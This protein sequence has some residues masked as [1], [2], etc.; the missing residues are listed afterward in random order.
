MGICIFW[1]WLPAPISI[2]GPCP[3]LVFDGPGPLFVFTGPGHNL[4]LPV[5]RFTVN[6]FYSSCLL[7]LTRRP[8][9][10]SYFLGIMW[11][12]SKLQL[13][14]ISSPD[15]SPSHTWLIILIRFI[16]LKNNWINPWMKTEGKCN[17]SV[18]NEFK[19]IRES[20]S[21]HQIMRVSK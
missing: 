17:E 21:L 6:V 1:P 19:I 20:D 9:L 8:L 10:C 13:F 4:C 2:E 18:N 3:Q 14:E 15:I 11:E 5:L 12:I 16:T 7:I